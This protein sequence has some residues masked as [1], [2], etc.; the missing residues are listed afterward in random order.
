VCPLACQNCDITPCTDRLADENAKSKPD[1]FEIELSKFFASTH[2][3]EKSMIVTPGPLSP[4]ARQWIHDSDS[5]TIKV[6]PISCQGVRPTGMWAD[7]IYE[8]KGFDD[9]TEDVKAAEGL[10]HCGMRSE[11][12]CR[13]CHED[14]CSVRMAKRTF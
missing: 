10:K 5:A 2:T 4:M 3:E 12:M 11:F 9:R 14:N 8:G 7:E 6:S 1:I 13:H